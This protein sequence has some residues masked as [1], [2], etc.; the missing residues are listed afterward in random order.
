VNPESGEDPLCVSRDEGAARVKHVYFERVLF[1]M[2]A[3]IQKCAVA[4]A[5]SPT[6][7]SNVVLRLSPLAL[8]QA[9]IAGLL[10]HASA[11]RPSV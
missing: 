2:R 11:E 8:M 1:A 5:K 4:N 7:I 6:E 9:L 3:A 10:E